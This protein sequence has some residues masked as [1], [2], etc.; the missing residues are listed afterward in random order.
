[1][2]HGEQRELHGGSKTITKRAARAEETKQD[3]SNKPR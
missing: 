2:Y 3:A 1:M